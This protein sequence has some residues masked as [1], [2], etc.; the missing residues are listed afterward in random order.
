MCIRF[1]ILAVHIIRETCLPEFVV[2][3]TS[4]HYYHFLYVKIIYSTVVIALLIR[5]MRIRRW[6]YRNTVIH[7]HNLLKTS[8]RAQ[9]PSLQKKIWQ[10]KAPLVI[11]TS[12]RSGRIPTSY[13]LIISTR[14]AVTRRQLTIKKNNQTSTSTYKLMHRL[15]ILMSPNSLY[16]YD[17]TVW[18]ICDAN[19]RKLLKMKLFN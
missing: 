12:R 4:I 19:V 11:K 1:Y 3:T 15:L 17:T 16:M 18:V 14:K 9:T 8:Y 6:T 13:V 5:N 10:Y 7:C 2:K